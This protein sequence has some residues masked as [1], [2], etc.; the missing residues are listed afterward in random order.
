MKKGILIGLGVVVAVV[1]IV[2]STVVGYRNR[3]VTG[4]EAVNAAWAQVDNVLQRRNDLIPN[5]VATVKGYAKQEKDIFVQIAEARAKMAGARNIPEKIGASQQMDSALARLLVVVEQYPQ[6]KSNQNFMALQDELAGT[7][8]R[9]AV[10]RMRYNETVQ[11]FNVMVRTFPGNV[12]AG[13]FGF[14]KKDAYLKTA[15]EA[16]Q[17]PK[18]EF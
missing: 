6:L 9:I 17:V 13:I 5:L 4:D 18:V 2:G 16:K 3:F 8:N 7:E 11:A 14:T 1:L 15:E 12:L 10:E